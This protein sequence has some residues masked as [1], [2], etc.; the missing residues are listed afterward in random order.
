MQPKE[1]H[2]EPGQS[3]S[4]V[5]T[6]IADLIRNSGILEAANYRVNAHRRFTGSWDTVDTIHDRYYHTFWEAKAIAYNIQR[7]FLKSKQELKY[8][9]ITF[10][11][12]VENDFT[13]ECLHWDSESGS[14]KSK[15]SNFL[16]DGKETGDEEIA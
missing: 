13:G 16:E 8:E 12:D 10:T 6:G 11:I 14:L 5:S 9:D 4:Q 7:N 1:Y 15:E 2:Q 3:Q